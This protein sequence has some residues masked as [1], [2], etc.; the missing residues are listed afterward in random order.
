MAEGGAGA[1]AA[2]LERLT[3]PL[4]AAAC[5]VAAVTLFNQSTC[6]GVEGAAGGVHGVAEGGAGASLSAYPRFQLKL[7]R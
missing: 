5:R 4:P 6:L 3:R 7:P 2:C 1:G